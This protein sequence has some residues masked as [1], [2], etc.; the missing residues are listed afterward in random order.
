MVLES[1]T[2]NKHTDT[3]FLGEK[4]GGLRQRFVLTELSN[5]IRLCCLF[6]KNSPAFLHS[7]IMASMSWPNRKNPNSKKALGCYEV[8]NK[9]KTITKH[10]DFQLSLV[11]I[12]YHLGD[13]VVILKRRLFCFFFS[14]ETAPPNA[15]EDN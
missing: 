8:K 1:V 4:D 9:T 11:F 6:S 3:A 12:F 15:G 2:V 14:F 13:T 7:I 10:L 5:R